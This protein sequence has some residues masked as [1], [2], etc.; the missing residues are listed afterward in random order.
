MAK[1]GLGKKGYDIMNHRRQMWWL[2]NGVVMLPTLKD[3]IRMHREILK[4]KK[5]VEAETNA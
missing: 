3:E 2:S 5:E 1:K 4:K